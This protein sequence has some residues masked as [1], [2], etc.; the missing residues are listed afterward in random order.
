MVELVDQSQTGSYKKLTAHVDNWLELHTGETFDLDT[1]CR[2]LEITQREN[3]NYVTTI[4]S[5]FVRANK[6]EKTNRI[7]TIVNTLVN[8]IDWVNASD[9][10]S[11]DLKF[12]TSHDDFDTSG[13]PFQGH[14]SVSP[15]DLIIIAGVSNMGKTTMCLNILWDN[16]D[17]YPCTLMGNEYVGSKFKRRVAH[18]TWANPL[19]EDGTPK[20]ELIERYDRWQDVI[21]PDNINII[22]WINLGDNFYM[23][24]KVLENIKSK[25]NKGIA[26][27][28]L[29]KDASKSLAVGGAF[30]EHL[31]S[32]YFLLDYN[33]LTVKKAK[34]WNH[35]NP[36]NRMY[37]FEIVSSGTQFHNI[38]EVKVCPRCHG[39]STMPN[40]QC[41]LCNRKG[42]VDSDG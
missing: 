3:R 16:M 35:Y 42:Y 38:R 41:E 14:V 37:G 19:K 33:R 15:G 18:M 31:A 17:T 34:E 29:Q 25:L 39:K 12:P 7:Y 22:D 24:G 10:E 36:N 4:L 20:F 1:I 40:V 9:S 6:L 13:F 2:Q 5:K 11:L 28:A 26:V 23:I 8:T 27:I 32:L 21:R 30:S